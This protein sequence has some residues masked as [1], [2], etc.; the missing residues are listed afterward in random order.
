MNKT[1]VCQTLGQNTTSVRIKFGD[2]LFLFWPLF[3]EMGI[4]DMQFKFSNMR[5]KHISFSKGRFLLHSSSEWWWL[6]FYFRFDTIFLDKKFPVYNILDGISS[7][8]YSWWVVI[9][10]VIYLVFLPSKVF[11]YP[12]KS[13]EQSAAK[14]TASS[15]SF[16]ASFKS[17]MS[18]LFK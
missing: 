3:G 2:Y 12:W 6:V 14:T 11:E 17:A 1:F 9:K 15:S 13:L 4:H 7:H 10:Q 8:S 18:S 16:L 5:P